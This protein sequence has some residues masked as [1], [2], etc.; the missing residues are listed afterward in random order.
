MCSTYSIEPTLYAVAAPLSS[1]VTIIF[2]RSSQNLLG[3]ELLVHSISLYIL[4]SAQPAG[5]MNDLQTFRDLGLA[6]ALGLLMGLERGWHMRSRD[7]G[8]RA[9]GLRTF[10]LIG[11]LGGI[12]GLLTE[13]VGLWLPALGFLGITLMTSIAYFRHSG[14]AEGIGLTTE[15]AMIL[16]YVFGLAVMTGYATVAAAATV[17]TTLLL[18]LKPTLHRIVNNLSEKEFY[19]AIKFLLISVVLLPI[20]PNKTYGPWDALNPYEIWWMVVLITGISFVGYFAMKITGT[21]LGAVITGFFGGLV[22][23]TAVTLGLSRFARRTKAM[24]KALASGI[25]AACATMFLRILLIAAAVNPESVSHLAIPL[26]SATTLLYLIAFLFWKTS[27]AKQ[28]DD[29]VQLQ[30]PFE[31]GMALKFGGLLALVFVLAKGLKI[32]LDDTGL[33]IL[34]AIS[35]IADVDAI[36]LSVSRMSLGEITIDTAVLSVLI[37]AGVNSLVKSG[38]ALIIG[39]KKI[40]LLVS[41]ALLGATALGALLYLLIK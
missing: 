32:W 33:F 34:A 12:T 7:D 41:S 10:G 28:T 11:L 29:D 23:S 17:V 27:S 26:I 38:M 40:G 22:S 9:A 39:G 20:L 5:A 15:I 14:K 24:E 19:A 37:A 13:P 4:V 16:T 35:G 2:I 18:S 1:V 3:Q 36:T 21:R 8:E 31:L 25:I 30:N 6:L